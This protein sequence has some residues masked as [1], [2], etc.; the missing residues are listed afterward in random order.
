MFLKATLR[1]MDVL[2]WLSGKKKNIILWYKNHL[3]LLEQGYSQGFWPDI[4]STLVPFLVFELLRIHCDFVTKKFQN[5][6]LV[7]SLH[8]RAQASTEA[9]GNILP[10][11]SPK[12]NF[13]SSTRFPQGPVQWDLIF[14]LKDCFLGCK[15]LSFF[16]FFNFRSFLWT[17]VVWWQIFVLKWEKER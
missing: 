10:I 4:L 16:F 8:R 7:S 11:V 2:Q 13:P 14:F 12:Y 17:H 6:H 9:T 3:S 1:I 5:R 15:F